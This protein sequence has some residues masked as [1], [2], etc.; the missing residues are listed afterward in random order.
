[1]NCFIELRRKTNS[2]ATVL[3]SLSAEPAS[4][5]LLIFAAAAWWQFCSAFCNVKRWNYEEWP[6]NGNAKHFLRLWENNTVGIVS[7]L[8]YS[9]QRENA[10]EIVHFLT[11]VVWKTMVF[12]VVATDQN[13]SYRTL[14]FC[15]TQYHSMSVCPAWLSD[16][17]FKIRVI[18]AQRQYS[19]QWGLTETL[20]L[21]IE[22][23]S[24][25]PA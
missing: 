13:C 1:M 18:F 5:C 25:W 14:H 17:E 19:S 9:F 15:E 4:E 8:N 20:F 21:L 16:S 2:E 22:N 10:G 7:V 12:D 6:A 11:S 24:Q 23:Y 3:E